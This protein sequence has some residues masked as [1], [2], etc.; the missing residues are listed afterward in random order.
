KRIDNLVWIHENLANGRTMTRWNDPKTIVLERLGAPGLLTG[1]S[2]DPSRPRTITSQTSFGP[3]IELHDYTGHH[4]AVWTD[5]QG[6]ATFTLPSNRDGR[7]ESYLCFSRTG[8]DRAIGLQEH[9]TTQ[10]FFG[11]ADLDVPPAPS[12]GSV[13]A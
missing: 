3:H 8:R 5:G 12:D 2:T 6:R 13:I 1:I 9:A 10:T 4:G 11:A 7:G